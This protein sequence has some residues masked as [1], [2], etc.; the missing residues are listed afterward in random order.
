MFN[1]AFGIIFSFIK[2]YGSIWNY[3]LLGAFV[4]SVLLSAANLLIGVTIKDIISKLEVRI[5]TRL[6]KIIERWILPNP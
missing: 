1:I 2:W 4:I 6:E 5:S 3:F